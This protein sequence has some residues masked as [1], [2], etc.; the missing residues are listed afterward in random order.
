MAVTAEGLHSIWI[1]HLNEKMVK[2]IIK[3][4]LKP[5]CILPIG[6]ST[7]KPQHKDEK[8]LSVIISKRK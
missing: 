6:Y 1:G 3:T 8:K 2:E 4:K 7:E 5:I